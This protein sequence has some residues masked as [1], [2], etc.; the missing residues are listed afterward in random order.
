MTSTPCE[1]CDH[2]HM[3]TRDKSPYQWMCVMFRR[4]DGTSPIAP[5]Q[6]AGREPYNRC[7]NINVGHCPLWVV[8]RDGQKEMGV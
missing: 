1:T 8:R 3:S 7:V 2:V 5:T 6:W 4:T